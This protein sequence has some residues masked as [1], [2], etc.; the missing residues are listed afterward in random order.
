MV[1]GVAER[2]QGIVVQVRWEEEEELGGENEKGRGVIWR[3]HLAGWVLI[4]L[5]RRWRLTRMVCG[6]EVIELVG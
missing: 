1:G 5:D 2:L 6:S 3:G 4:E